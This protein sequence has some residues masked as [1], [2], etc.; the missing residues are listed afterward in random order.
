[1]QP[2]SGPT[3]VDGVRQARENSDQGSVRVRV[4]LG[5][6]VTGTYQGKLIEAEPL[7]STG[8]TVPIG[9]T[10]VVGSAAPGGRGQAVILTIR[11]EVAMPS[12]R[13]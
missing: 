12:G 1:M 11:P 3:G 8:L 13:D 10:I 9:Q 6:L 5:S 4:W 7:L 2:S